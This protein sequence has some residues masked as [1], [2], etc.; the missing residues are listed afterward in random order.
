MP[1]HRR[2]LGSATQ[3]DGYV[4]EY[5]KGLTHSRTWAVGEIV[6]PVD[7]GALVVC[8]P[9][10]KEYTRESSADQGRGHAAGLAR[11]THDQRCL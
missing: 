8:F 5:P 1:R 7:G 9:E 6:K 11:K 4:R 2:R 10:D 3:R